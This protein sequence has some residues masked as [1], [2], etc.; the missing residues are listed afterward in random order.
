MK[1][2]KILKRLKKKAAK[3]AFSLKENRGIVIKAIEGSTSSAELVAVVRGIKLRGNEEN[4]LVLEKARLFKMD[5]IGWS[6]LFE[7]AEDGSEL[8]EVADT[9]S[10]K[11]S[12]LYDLLEDDE[13]E[14]D[15]PKI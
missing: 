8:K 2:P 13:D 7:K 4:R 3:I 14:E 10:Y 15:E 9:M 5:S 11:L 12:P 6:I 1:L